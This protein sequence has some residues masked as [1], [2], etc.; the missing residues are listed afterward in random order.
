VVAG[1]LAVAVTRL[2]LGAHWF[3]DVISGAALA[4]VFVTQ[5]A[6]VTL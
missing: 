3:A 2:Y 5:G 4:A 1:V 6:A